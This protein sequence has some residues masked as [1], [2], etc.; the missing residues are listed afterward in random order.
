MK[1]RS[2]AELTQ[3][4]F[5]SLVPEVITAQ[6]ESSL[7][8]TPATTRANR[9]W[10]RAGRTK[11][12]GNLCWKLQSLCESFPLSNGVFLQLQPC[13][14]RPRGARQDSWN[15]EVAKDAKRSSLPYTVCS[16]SLYASRGHGVRKPQSR[17][18]RGGM[19][20]ENSKRTDPRPH[21]RQVH[22]LVIHRDVRKQGPKGTP[23]LRAQEGGE[24]FPRPPLTG[25]HV[26]T[27]LRTENRFQPVFTCDSR[28]FQSPAVTGHQQNQTG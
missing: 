11:R 21:P 14:G 8:S 28:G 23:G 1:K 19:R 3:A 10:P 18:G 2:L 12:A 15:R 24:H 20:R 6:P 7:S 27:T 22:L 9:Q 4:L 25:F 5:L 26:T 13:R 17:R 16:V